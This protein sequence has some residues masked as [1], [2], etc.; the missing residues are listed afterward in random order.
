MP[1]QEAPLDATIHEKIAWARDCFARAGDRLLKDPRIADLLNRLSN[2]ITDSHRAMGVSG[3]SE[4]CR[5]CEHQE[6]GSCCG[7]GLENRYSG[8][9]LLINLLLGVKLP[10][11][12]T[13]PS[14]CHFLGD[15]GCRL[16]ARHVI[17]V[18]YVCRKITDRIDPE[19]IA[20]LR[21]AEGRELDILFL[22]NEHIKKVLRE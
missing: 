9:L 16:L 4:E 10:P 18:N 12:R 5:Q 3:I 22:L 14:N 6:G 2:A 13:A 8:T 21:E 15:K 20:P 19:G 17:C 7:A 1:I 11:K